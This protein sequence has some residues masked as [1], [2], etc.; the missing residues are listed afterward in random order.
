MK[1]LFIPKFDTEVAAQ[2][3]LVCLANASSFNST[4]FNQPLTTYAVGWRDPTDFDSMLDA[5]FPP[6]QVSRRFSFRAHTNG[7]EFLQDSDDERAIGSDFKRVKYT[8][9]ETESRTI[10]RGLTVFVDMDEVTD[11]PDWEQV[12][13]GRLMRRCMRNDLVSASATMVAAATNTA[14]TWNSSADPDGDLASLIESAG[15]VIGFDP[16]RAAFFGN[17]WLKRMLAFRAQDNAGAYASAMLTSEQLAD[18]L[19]LERV[20]KVSARYQAKTSAS[21]KSKA[22]GGNYVVVYY[23]EDGIGPED[24]SHAKGFFT[25][26]EGGTR[27]R[28]YVR[29]VSEKI[30]AVTV[31]RY[32]RFV[33]TSTTGLKMYTVS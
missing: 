9:T 25:P 30:R 10:N 27:Y 28:V 14:K 20:V 4:F 13:T 23:A 7:E 5:L 12:Y 31:E 6:V 33:M 29:E 18:L 24:P 15:N 2:H 1:E 8:G 19:G 17:T 26:C 32:R 11:M 21:T 16:N 22:G 3:N